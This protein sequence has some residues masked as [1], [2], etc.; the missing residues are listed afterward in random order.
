MRHELTV[1]GKHS[2]GRAPAL[3][4]FVVAGADV[5]IIC[6]RHPTAVGDDTYPAFILARNQIDERFAGAGG[7]VIAQLHQAEANPDEVF[8]N[9]VPDLVQVRYFDLAGHAMRAWMRS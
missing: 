5:S 6:D 3:L 4:R 2:A 1:A 8:V 7:H 9:E